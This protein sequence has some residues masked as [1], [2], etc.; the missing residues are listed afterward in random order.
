MEKPNSTASKL[1]IN[2]HNTPPIPIDNKSRTGALNKTANEAAAIKEPIICST[3]STWGLISTKLNAG[4]G[5]KYK[6]IA[7]PKVIL[8]TMRMV[9]IARVIPDR[10]WLLMVS[11]TALIS[12]TPGIINKVQHTST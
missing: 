7:I 5:L 11:I 9:L 1:R 6:A 10:I 3:D 8:P 2:T 12:G 4:I